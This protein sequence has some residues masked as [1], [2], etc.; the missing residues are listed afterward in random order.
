MS[1]VKIEIKTLFFNT[2]PMEMFKFFDDFL[3]SFLNNNGSF[4]KISSLIRY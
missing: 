3:N 1:F 4:G 2:N